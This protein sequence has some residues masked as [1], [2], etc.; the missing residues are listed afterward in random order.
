MKQ[1]TNLAFIIKNGGEL[2]NV[3]AS[4]KNLEVA[5]ASQLLIKISKYITNL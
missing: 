4:P 5:I 3:G 2:Q 1:T